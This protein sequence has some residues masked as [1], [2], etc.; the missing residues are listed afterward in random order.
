MNYESQYRKR[1]VAEDSRRTTKPIHQHMLSEDNYISVKR[2]NIY[3][4]L[5]LVLLDILVFFSQ[6]IIFDR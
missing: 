6:Y 1:C 3:R 5:Y 2:S 4:E